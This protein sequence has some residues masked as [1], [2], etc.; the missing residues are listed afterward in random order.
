MWRG[1]VSHQTVT[2]EPLQVSDDNLRLFVLNVK[3]LEFRISQEDWI[4]TESDF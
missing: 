2:E 4:K 3:G 1:C